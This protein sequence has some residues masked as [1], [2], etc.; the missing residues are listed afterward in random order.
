MKAIDYNLRYCQAKHHIGHALVFRIPT[1]RHES[2]T[3]SCSKESFIYNSK[4]HAH[5][6]PNLLI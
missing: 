4:L 5:K 2:N 1:Y 6:T 3:E